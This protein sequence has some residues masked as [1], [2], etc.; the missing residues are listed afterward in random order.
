VHA[1]AC[2]A[3]QHAARAVAV[4]LGLF[5][6]SAATTPLETDFLETPSE[7]LFF[8]C[9]TGDVERAAAAL[10]AGAAVDA[11]NAHG[12]TPLLVA[13]GGVGP[14]ELVRLLLTSGAS[15]DGRD[16]QGWTPLIY[17]ASSGQLALMNE[18][19]RAGADVNAQGSGAGWTPLS[20][21]SYRGH[22]HAIALLLSAGARADLIAEGRTPR[23]WAEAG[24]H[25]TAVSAFDL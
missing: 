22:P 20:R 14:V 12:I 1:A 17:A 24:G 6:M 16:A 8:A 19:L 11:R 10:G 23:A 21:A 4:L 7:S 3:R 5:L 15:A 9:M 13:C 25:D 2:A 18:L